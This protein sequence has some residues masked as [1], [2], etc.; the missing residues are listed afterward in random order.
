MYGLTEQKIKGD[1]NCQ[2]RVLYL[3]SAVTFAS[4]QLADALC[5]RQ[6]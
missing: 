4:T 1:G 2:V 5:L 3:L 6:F